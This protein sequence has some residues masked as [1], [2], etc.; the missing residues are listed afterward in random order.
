M[1]IPDFSYLRYALPSLPKRLIRPAALLFIPAAQ[2]GR[3]SRLN[4]VQLSLV[5]PSGGTIAR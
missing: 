2:M 4:A 1:R 5:T 3:I